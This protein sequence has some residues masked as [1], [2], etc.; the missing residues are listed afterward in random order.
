MYFRH[1]LCSERTAPSSSPPAGRG[2]APPG[3]LRKSLRFIG[4]LPC[5]VRFIGLASMGRAVTC[6]AWP[7]RSRI[8][9]P[10]VRSCACLCVPHADRRCRVQESACARRSRRGVAA[11]LPASVRPHLR[12]ISV[13]RPS[14]F[15]AAPPKGRPALS[16][17]GR[18]VPSR[19]SPRASTIRSICCRR[20]SRRWP[21]TWTRI[22]AFSIR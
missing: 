12:E 1:G 16:A 8:A 20:S 10:T 5:L 9:P 3:G 21:G 2:V 4:P 7:W 22:A 11:P 18:D 13:N 19:M 15:P 14:P 6:P 17:P